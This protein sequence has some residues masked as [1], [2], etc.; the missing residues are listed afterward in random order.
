VT[1]GR[2]PVG[3]LGARNFEL[4][5][6]G[7]AQ[8]IESV[9]VSELPFS[10]LLALDTSASMGG[11]PLRQLQEGARA[12][13]ETLRPGDRASM[14]T[15]S[16]VVGPPTPWTAD[17]GSLSAAIER[18]QAAGTTSLFDAAVA[19]MVR[20]DPE[21]GRRN[22]VILFTDGDDTSSWLPDSAAYDLAAR[23]D[24]VVYG[25]TTGPV[26]L[27]RETALQWRSGIRLTREQ[28]IV[29]SADFLSSL[30][31]RTGGKHLRS[32]ATDLRA[33]FAQIVS[34]FRTRYVLYYR[35]DGVT[36]TGWHPI[37]VRLKAS[38]GHVTARRGYER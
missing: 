12:A 24:I 26:A 29:S 6:S 5:D 37:D 2:N 34:E 32:A 21:P 1:D 23:T 30:A 9:E 27:A 18:L 36:A 22:L 15:F 25:I 35:P 38:R 20:R 33:A 31:A 19:A 7:V 10:V 8:T 16:A 17:R 4:F 3:G 11:T 28:S 14:M 13:V